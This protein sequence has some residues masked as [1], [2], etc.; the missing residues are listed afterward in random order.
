MVWWHWCDGTGV[1]NHGSGCN[2]DCAE[3]EDDN[4]TKYNDY[5]CDYNVDNVL[6]I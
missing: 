1:D 3:D 4:S 6:L 5:E 2:G